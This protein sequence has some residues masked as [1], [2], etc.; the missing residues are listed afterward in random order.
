MCKCALGH[1]QIHSL[2]HNLVLIIIFIDA[3]VEMEKAMKRDRIEV[4]DRQVYILCPRFANK[5]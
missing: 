2:F 3:L 1:S 5:S 4:N